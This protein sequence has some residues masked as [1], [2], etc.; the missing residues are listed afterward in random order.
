[1]RK[2]KGWEE[3]T[4]ELPGQVA[5]ARRECVNG[6]KFGYCG[7][8]Q[9]RIKFGQESLVAGHVDWLDPPIDSARHR[10]RGD[11]SLCSRLG[12]QRV[13]KIHQLTD[14][15]ADDQSRRSR[16]GNPPRSVRRSGRQRLGKTRKRDHPR[17][18]LGGLE[19]AENLRVL[20]C[21]SFG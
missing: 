19:A 10:H 20:G 13:A 16:G 21:E 6:A 12:G 3:L 8:R 11:A 1:L 7:A 14:A 4:S 2:I 9:G 18:A 5:G 17:R 15:N